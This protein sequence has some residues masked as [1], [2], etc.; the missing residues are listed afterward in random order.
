M[1]PVLS[2]IRSHLPNCMAKHRG[3]DKMYKKTGEIA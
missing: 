1:L 3:K 2:L